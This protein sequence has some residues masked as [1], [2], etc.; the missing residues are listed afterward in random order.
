MHRGRSIFSQL[1]DHIP[2]HVLRSLVNKYQGNNRVRHFTCWQQ[3]LCMS[4]AQLTGRES[5][6]DIENCL[7]SLGNSA[8]HSG[9]TATVSR[10]T[11]A[12]ANET[13]PWQIYRDLAHYLIARARTL[14][15]NHPAMV[16]ELTGTIYAFDATVIELCLS[17]FPWAKAHVHQKTTAAVKVHTLFDVQAQLPVTLHVTA[18][19]LSDVRLLDNLVIESGSYY[20]LDRGYTDFVRLRSIDQA[21]AFFVIRARDNIRVRRIYSSPVD[22]LRGLPADQV[23]VFHVPLSRQKYPDTIRRIRFFDEKHHRHFIFLTNNF[24][25]DAFSITELY[26]MRWQVELF[27]RW[28]KQHLHIKSFYGTS[29]N[30]VNTQ[31]WIAVSVFV[32]IAIVKKELKLH[33]LSLY[34]ILQILSVTLF[35][36]E[37]ILQVL[38]ATPGNIQDP[39]PHNQLKLFNF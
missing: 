35:E 3:Y 29:S 16:H 37:S 15:R 31:I 38:T 28:I 4:F 30:A 10:S 33:D 27:F 12:D 11:L 25:L 13:R 7:R 26:R 21:G 32:L 5:L 20:I 36:K 18:A 14:Y 9:I 19:N 22:K 8:Y 17:L 39:C 23:G 34:T 6:R 1:M 24:I 2:K